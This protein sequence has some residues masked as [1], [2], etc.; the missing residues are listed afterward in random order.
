MFPNMDQLLTTGLGALSGDFSQDL[1]RNLKKCQD[2]L[3]LTWE[4]YWGTS[5]D[6]SSGEFCHAWRFPWEW[7]LC[8]SSLEDKLAWVSQHLNVLH[9]IFV[10]C[11]LLRGSSFL[12]S[13]SFCLRT[14]MNCGI[15]GWVT[16]SSLK[17]SCN[18][19]C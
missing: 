18:G 5:D 3:S 14:F 12:R 7:D 6:F 1:A 17:L 4:L 13:L 15:A 2:F 10:K 11:E 8:T 16:V 9:F 19:L